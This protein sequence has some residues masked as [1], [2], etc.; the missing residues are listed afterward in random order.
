MHEF[1]CLVT[2]GPRGDLG[3]NGGLGVHCNG[4]D[5]RLPRSYQGGHYPPFGGIDRAEP[6]RISKQAADFGE[7]PSQR[8]SVFGN[9]RI[10]I[11]QSVVEVFA[12]GRQCAALRVYPS[13]AGSTGVSLRSQ[14]RD[15]KLVSYH[16]RSGR[17]GT[18][19]RTSPSRPRREAWTRSRI[20]AAPQ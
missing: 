2:R 5:S 6:P 14:G 9:L 8:P 4:E 20:H 3:H 1:G 15:S 13:L 10:F 7:I 17:C 12:N 11:D 18:S 19:T 16:S